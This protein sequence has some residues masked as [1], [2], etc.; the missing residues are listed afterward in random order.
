MCFKISTCER[1]E[2]TFVDIEGV[3][4]IRFDLAK[5]TNKYLDIAIHCRLLNKS[6]IRAID[7]LIDLDIFALK[8]N[9]SWKIK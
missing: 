3:L 7:Q 9:N 2:K 6:R 4:K 1:R 8:A 5:T